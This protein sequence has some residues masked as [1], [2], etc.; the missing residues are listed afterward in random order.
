MRRSALSDEATD[1]QAVRQIAA[2]FT[3][4]EIEQIDDVRFASRHASRA[5]TIRFLIKK[6]LEAFAGESPAISP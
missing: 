6:G 1:G 3:A 5:E 4:G 2:P